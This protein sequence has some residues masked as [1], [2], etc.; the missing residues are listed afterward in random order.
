V[1]VDAVLGLSMTST[2][3]GLVVVEGLDADGATVD[4][5]A[6]DVHDERVQTSE[7]A[8]AAVR[9]T[10]AMV[11]ARG[12]RLHSVGVTW[13]EDADAEASMLMRSLADAGFDNVVPIRM[14]EA[15]EALARGIAAVIGY[16]TTAV[17]VVEPD[18]VIALVVNARTGAIQTAFN[19]AVDS[20]ESLVGWLSTVFT[21]ADWQPEALVLVGSH[22]GVFAHLLPMLEEV[23]SVP[24]F[25]PEEAQLALA[26]GAALASAKSA[27]SGLADVVSE[28]VAYARPVASAP[29]R[30]LV[31]V[32]AATMLVAGVVTFVVSVSV[33]VSLELTPHRDAPS[34]V[35]AVA[36]AP[37]A[38]VVARANPAVLD[39]P[40]AVPPAPVPE[41]PAPAPEAPAP[42]PEAPPADVAPPETDP[43]PA[44]NF[45]PDP[46]FAAHPDAPVAD[47]SQQVPAAVPAPPV[48]AP[49]PLVPAQVPA[50]PAKKPGILTRI[51]ERLGIGNDDGQPLVPPGPPFSMPPG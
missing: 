10:E 30:R 22:S 2:S 16:D 33:A 23:L 24:V 3:V 26:R 36:S 27:E 20:D 50:V 4:R 17:C 7:Q 48:T 47:A 1:Q 41:A 9:R 25:A 38:P 6:F 15:T 32:G 42:A 44:M 14:P 12:L 35:P 13:S 29:R 19:H 46:P 5:D 49:G 51:K 39:P 28:F 21:R 34:P 45:L 40:V 8:A 31:P 37:E 11:A 18:A 43:A